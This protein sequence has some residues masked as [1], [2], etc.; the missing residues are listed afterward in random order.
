MGRILLVALEE[1]MG[2]NGLNA[3]LHLAKLEQFIDNYPPENLNKQFDFA[4]IAALLTALEEM[5]GAR[6]GRGLAQ[7]AGRAL[8]SNGLKTFGALAGA[9]DLAFQVLPL[10]IKLKIAV[11]AIAKVFNSV[12]DQTSNSTEHPDHFIYTLERC[13]MCWQRKTDKPTCHV[14]VGIIQEALKWMSGGR[15]FKI[16]ILTCRGSGDDMGRLKIYKEPL[17][18]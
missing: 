17:P 13:S 12:T 11:P 9:G 1:V 3:I 5:Y 6:G 2:K 16:D 14:A 15:E 7:R 18:D 4:Y 10:Q 8:F